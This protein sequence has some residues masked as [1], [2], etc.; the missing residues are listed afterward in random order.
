[1]FAGQTLSEPYACD[2]SMPPVLPETH[3]IPNALKSAAGVGNDLKIFGDDYPT[4]DGTCIRDYIHIEDLADAHIRAMEVLQAEKNST[5]KSFNLGTGEG[6]SVKDVLTACESV[7]GHPIS[8][9]VGLRRDGDPSR[10]V[11]NA[12]S[13]KALLGWYPKRT[14]IAEIVADAWRWEKAYAKLNL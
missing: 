14:D 13:A 4:A 9:T 11:A 7:V 3:L 5:F 6:F 2:I 10:L 8:Y 12:S 1:M